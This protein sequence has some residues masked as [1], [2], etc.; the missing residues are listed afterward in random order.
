MKF[1]DLRGKEVNINVGSRKDNPVQSRSKFQQKAKEIIQDK[2]P[3]EIVLEEF[4]I[5]GSRL[6]LDLFIPRL[7]MAWEIDGSQHAHF[8]AFYHK[9]RI[10]NKFAGQVKRDVQKD[11]WCENNN[12]TLVRV[13]KIEDLND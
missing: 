1:L 7:K 11:I 5:P 13:S 6:K 12:I 8:N 2:Y 9:S 4:T 10:E 3:Y